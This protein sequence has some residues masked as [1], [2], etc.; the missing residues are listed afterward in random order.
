MGYCPFPALGRD[1]E[2]CRD[3]KG[4]AARRAARSNTH[5]RAQQRPRHRRW[6]R[7][8]ILLSPRLRH[9]FEVVTLLNWDKVVGV[10]TRR[11][12]CTQARLTTEQARA[13]QRWNAR[14]TA[15]AHAQEMGPA[16]ATCFLLALGCDINFVPRHGW[17]GAELTLYHDID[18]RSRHRLAGWCCDMVLDVVTWPVG[19]GVATPF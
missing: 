12:W 15:R 13:Q 4:Q 6:A 19:G 2:W 8:L 17:A 7:D 3:K 16:R 18:L 9:Q 11:A 1:P 5:D 14:A 10:T